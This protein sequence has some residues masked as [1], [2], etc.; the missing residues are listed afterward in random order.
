MALEISSRDYL[1]ASLVLFGGVAA[2]MSSAGCSGH[3]ANAS[4][5]QQRPLEVYRDETGADPEGVIGGLVDLG[6]VTQGGHCV[7]ALQFHNP[8]DTA[9]RLTSYSSS[10]ECLTIT[11]LPVDLTKGAPVPARVKINLQK[12]PSFTGRLEV[13]VTLVADEGKSIPLRVRFIV[14]VAS[15]S[16]DSG[17][18]S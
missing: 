3:V 2:L 13:V 11:G 16:A 12:E 15:G 18:G 17:R 6:T 4:A 10:C 9:V 7:R 8:N 14:E 5:A 1:R